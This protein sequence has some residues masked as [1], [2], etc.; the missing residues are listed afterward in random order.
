M[1]PRNLD[2]CFKE[3]KNDRIKRDGTKQCEFSGCKELCCVGNA[4]CMIGMIR[5]LAKTVTVLV[6]A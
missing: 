5:E 2:C 3:S 4:G 1:A 6:M